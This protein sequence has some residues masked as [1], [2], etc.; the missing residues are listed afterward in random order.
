MIKI[1][2]INSKSK[3]DEATHKQF[4]K[5]TDAVVRMAEEVKKQKRFH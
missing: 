1:I 3:M 2:K 4:S 5:I